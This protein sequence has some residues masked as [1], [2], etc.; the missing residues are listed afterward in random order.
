M[1][2][3]RFQQLFQLVADVEVVFYRRL[4][5]PGDDDNLVAARRH[6]L[7][8]A[9]LDDGLVHQRQHLFGHGLGGRQE[10]RPQSRRR[11]H[12]FAHLLHAKKD[13]RLCGENCGLPP[14][15]Q[16]RSAQDI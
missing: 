12:R 7:F 8:H 11:K 10:P 4:A 1:L 14:S 16:W 3:L 13:S 9:V 2:A 15:Y 5:A 6:R